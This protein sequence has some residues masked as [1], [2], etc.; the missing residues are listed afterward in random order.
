MVCCIAKG[1]ACSCAAIVGNAGKI[2][3]IA[4]GPNIASAASSG[5]RRRWRKV[6]AGVIGV[7]AHATRRGMLAASRTAQK[8]RLPHIRCDRRCRKTQDRPR[9]DG[10]A[11]DLRLGRSLLEAVGEDAIEHARL[12]R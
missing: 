8:K 2:V 6:G 5:A 1:L 10:P 12:A 11:W 4:N 9:T 7:N 3:S